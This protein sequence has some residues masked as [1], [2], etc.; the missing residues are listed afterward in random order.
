MLKICIK[1]LVFLASSL[2][3]TNAQEACVPLQVT[4]VALN[5]RSLPNV[6]G[7]VV[8]KL[9]KGDIICAYSQKGNWLRIDN[10][11]VSGKYLVKAQQ[12]P[13]STTTSSSTMATP[14][15][16]SSQVNISYDYN[17]TKVKSDMVGEVTVSILVLMF[18]VYI[19]MLLVGMAGKVV[20]YFD[21]ADLVISLLPWLTLFIAMI[22]YGIY[23]PTE[24]DL[25][26]EKM[27]L[28]QQIVLYIGG[29]LFIGFSIWAI[30]LSIKY[31][32]SIPLGFA[33]GIFK[34]L[35]GLIGVL[36]LISQVFTMKDE[37]TK[38]KDFW[39]A[40]LVFGAFWWLGKKLING[41]KVYKD[42]GWNLPK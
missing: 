30:L 21:E 1:I 17:N 9:S 34:L 3:A 33:Y 36:V 10:G 26:P 19:V 6:S 22:I 32:R 14:L 39:F 28:I 31:N 20:V 2:I 7:N 38:R 35:S 18:A 37:N 16:V 23:Q 12:Q 25:N 41:K 13:L 15:P 4:A 29:A 40:I 24:E 5:V 8:T 27:L 42:K 11:W